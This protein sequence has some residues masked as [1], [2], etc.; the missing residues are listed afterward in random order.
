[1]TDNVYAPPKAELTPIHDITAGHPF[2][3][4]SQRKFLILFFATVGM[5]QV[6]WHFKNWNQYRRASGDSLWPVPR[7]IF[8]VFFV[9]ALLRKVTARAEDLGQAPWNYRSTAW[10]LVV[11]LL[12]SAMLEQLVKSTVGATIAAMCPLLILA[13]MSL[14]YLAAQEHI[15]AACGDAQGQGNDQLTTANIVW[16]VIGAVLWLCTLIGVFAKSYLQ[17]T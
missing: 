14:C 16:C 4:V 1:M 12:A 13:P 3:V 6:F 2:Y 9:H 17:Q 15:N 8:S 10:Q 5:Y 7:A 11:L